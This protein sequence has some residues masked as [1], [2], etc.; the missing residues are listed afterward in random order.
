MRKIEQAMTRAIQSRVNW[1]QGNTEVLQYD[2]G[3]AEVALHGNVIATVDYCPRSGHIA[4]TPARATLI[5]W[6]T[7]T[8]CSRLR[9]LGIAATIK[10]GVPYLDGE[11]V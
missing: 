4:V 5:A 7:V 8:T 9:A 10:A 3:I 11:A 6:P 1:R 2:G